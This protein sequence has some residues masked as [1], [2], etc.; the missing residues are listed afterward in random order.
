MSVSAHIAAQRTDHGVPHAVSCRALGVA[1]STF[2]KWRGRPPTPAKRRRA[3][4][5]VEVFYLTPAEVKAAIVDEGLNTVVTEFIEEA[6]AEEWRV[7][8][9]TRHGT[10]ARA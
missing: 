1:P 5:D 3:E 8:E 10:S 4:L 2:Y 6:P 9:N 7:S